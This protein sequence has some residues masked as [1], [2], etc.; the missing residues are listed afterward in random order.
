[1]KKREILLSLA[2]M[3][4]MGAGGCGNKELTLVSEQVEIELGTELDATVTNYVVLD[5]KEASEATVDFSAVDVMKAGTYTANVSYK[6]QIKSFGVVVKDTT[7]PVV[8]VVEDAVVEVGTPLYAEDVIKEITE[9]S[10]SVEIIFQ[11]PEIAKEETESIEGTKLIQSTE[12]VEEPTG[13]TEDIENAEESFMLGN[14]LCSNDFI[15]YEKTGEYDAVVVVMDASGNRVEVPVHITVGEAPIFSGI[16]D[17]TVA[18]ATE[19]IDYLEGVTAV[20]CNGKDITENIVCDSAKVDLATEGEYEISYTV[21]DENGFKAVEAATVTVKG[22]GKKSDSGKSSTGKG[23]TGKS[24]TESTDVKKNS[25]NSTSGNGNITGTSDTSGG[26]ETDNVSGSDSASG[27]TGTDNAS[28]N[29]NASGSENTSNSNTSSGS[30][31][32]DSTGTGDVTDSS[33]SQTATQIQTSTPASSESISNSDSGSA[34]AGNTGEM[35]VPDGIV[36]EEWDPDKAGSG[37][38]LSAGDGT[39]DTVN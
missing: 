37:E 6:E 28:N 31:V 29:S 12:T 16:E 9:L 30:N 25:S 17:I 21:E 32:S 5:E 33:G 2:V 27:S 20:D 24:N 39:F 35:A 22:D 11:K 10:G 23:S 8:E 15:V 19:G 4:A 7:A 14:V 34:D 13:Q 1:M 38:D 18:V 3:A 26:A 36:I